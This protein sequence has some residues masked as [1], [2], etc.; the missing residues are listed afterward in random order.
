MAGKRLK[1]IAQ[2]PTHIRSFRNIASTLPQKAKRYSS[3]T[4]MLARTYASTKRS[5]RMALPPVRVQ[6][7]QRPRLDEP[8]QAGDPEEREGELDQRARQ[9]RQVARDDQPRRR[10]E[11]ELEWQP[12]QRVA[13]PV[14]EELERD[15]QAPEQ[16]DGTVVEQRQRLG[17][18]DPE[19]A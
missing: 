18:L 13:E 2:K 12:R 1:K 14:G 17:V 9:R 11:Q 8:D 10:V 5:S 6:P 16:H 4:L 7:P 19:G 3:A 15:Q